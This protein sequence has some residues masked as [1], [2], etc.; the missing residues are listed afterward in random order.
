MADW[1]VHNSKLQIKD[2]LGTVSIPPTYLHHTAHETTPPP[3]ATTTTTTTTTGHTEL[4]SPSLINAQ[5]SIK[6][7][8]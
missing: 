6:K 3:A 8:E 2:I 4:R 1:F 5:I 7:E